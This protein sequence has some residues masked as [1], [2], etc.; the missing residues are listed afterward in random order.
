[1]ETVILMPGEEFF[2][3]SSSV[4][5]EIAG[6]KGDVSTFVPKVVSD[7]LKKKFNY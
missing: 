7:A 2:F 3:I 1:M 6:L 4:V 5:K